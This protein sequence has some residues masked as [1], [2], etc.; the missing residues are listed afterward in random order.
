MNKNKTYNW[1]LYSLS[2]FATLLSPISFIGIVDTAYHTGYRNYI[3]Q[4]GI[5]LA[6]PILYWVLKQMMD[7]EDVFHFIGQRFGHGSFLFSKGLWTL[8]QLLRIGI[9]LYIPSKMLEQLTNISAYFWILLLALWAYG[10]AR[11]GLL[12]VVRY[13][14]LYAVI[15]FLSMIVIAFKM[16]TNGILNQTVPSQ[17]DSFST[18][19]LLGAS[20]QTFSSYLVSPDIQER[21]QRVGK[22][23]LL[24]SILLNATLGILFTGFLYV[25]G[26]SLK[27]SGYQFNGTILLEYAK[28]EGLWIAIP[29][30]IGVL[31]SAQTTLSTGYEILEK[32]YEGKYSLP[33]IFG[34]NIFISSSLVALGGVSSYE[35]FVGYVGIFL[36]IISSLVLVGLIF[37]NFGKSMSLYV[38]LC[39]CISLGV[40]R[41]FFQMEM[42]IYGL[43]PLISG[44]CSA[45]I[46]IKLK[47]KA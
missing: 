43:V 30:M 27:Q 22:A 34:L 10:V 29:V 12:A 28:S 24:K 20:F 7:Y 46:L 6:L 16:M 4:F 2:I 40:I 41:V 36:S 9:V 45:W 26:V 5:L 25:I 18:W 13:D 1:I 11:G 23:K 32:Q 8:Y 35:F 17:R 21:F 3:A 33:I 19:I 15:L 47:Q 37:S 14:S 42:W 31:L 39:M 38:I 44:L